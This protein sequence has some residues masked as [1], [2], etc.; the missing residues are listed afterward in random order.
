MDSHSSVAQR[1]A[2]DIG[3][4]ALGKSATP[5]EIGY[6]PPRPGKLANFTGRYQMPK[7]YYAS[8]ASMVIRGHGDYL[9]AN[10]SDGGTS[11]IYPT[12]GDDFVDR[13]NRATVHFTR[14]AQ[15]QLTG[16]TCNLFQVFVAQKLPDQ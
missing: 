5:P 3:A 11:V 14:D 4:I 6:V 2:G 1:I 7:N 8:N 12:G 9:E 16:L 10:W 13:A 15:A